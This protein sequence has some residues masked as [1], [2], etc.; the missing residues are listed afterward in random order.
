MGR[1]PIKYSFI[2]DYEGNIICTDSSTL[3]LRN[4]EPAILKN[5][6]IEEYYKIPIKSKFD[7][8][9]ILAKEGKSVNP[10]SIIFHMNPRYSHKKIEKKKKKKKYFLSGFGTPISQLR[11]HTQAMSWIQ[12]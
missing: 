10:D 5:L 9:I 11:F 3:K 8:D 1:S 2:I 12:L 7:L 4:S 6:L